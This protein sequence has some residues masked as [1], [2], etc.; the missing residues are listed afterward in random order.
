[1]NRKSTL[2]AFGAALALL[3]LWFVLLWGPQGGRL[4]EAQE[5][6]AAAD[7]IN[8]E[9][10]LRVARLEAAQEGAPARMAELEELRRAVPDEPE[11]AQFILDANQAASD[12]GVDF[13]SISPTPPA[14]GVGGL[15]PVITLAINVT[16]GYFAVL[17][18]LERVDDL[19]RIVVIDS[20]T[21]TPSGD[22]AQPELSVSITGRM[23]ANA[24]PQL[25]PDPSLAP[26]V[27]GTTTTTA[28]PL[29]VSS[30]DG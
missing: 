16:G 21:L 7:Q 27:D 19:P 4:D 18:Y 1:M 6:E 12:A 3:G 20:I 23:F 8:S 28:A 14:L 26:P 5:R 9:L 25:A 2:I 29:N 10:E 15:P 30:T 13:L 17:D 11:L 22:G 24:A